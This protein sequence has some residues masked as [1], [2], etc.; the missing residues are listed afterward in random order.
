MKKKNAV[1]AGALMGAILATPVLA[2][3]ETACLQHNRILSWKALDGRTLLVTDRSQNRYTVRMNGGCVGLN[4]AAA[5]LVFQQWMN[6]SC[7]ASGD[8]IG[9]RTPGLGYASCSVAGVQ[10]GAPGAVPG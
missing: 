1:L 2:A 5:T 4:N 10:A 9:V 6:L 8:M 7:L 3:S